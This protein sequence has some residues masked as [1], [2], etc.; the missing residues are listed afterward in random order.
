MIFMIIESIIGLLV[1]VAVVYLSWKVIK[2]DGSNTDLNQDGKTDI[3]DAAVVVEKV[4][5]TVAKA[6]DVNKD[7]KVSIDD[8]KVVAETVKTKF[9]ETVEK[10]KSVAKKIKKS[11]QEV[12]PEPV[13]SKAPERARNKG[14]LVADSPA[15]P[16]VNEA[17]IGGKAPEKKP[18]PK[19]PKKPKMTVV[20]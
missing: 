9:N 2:R 16:D 5:A 15:T 14:K 10:S 4:V 12:K 8:A 19:K 3:K 7:G 17:W 13:V 1:I 20:K 18:K 6:A 11:T